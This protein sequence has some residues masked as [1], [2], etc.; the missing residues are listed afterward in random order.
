MELE[1][2]KLLGMETA[3]L[4]LSLS[5][6]EFLV[7]AFS[8]CLQYSLIYLYNLAFYDLKISAH[9]VRSGDSG[10]ISSW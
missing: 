9:L 10:P 5:L 2:G 8:A 1:T 3:T 7:F 6:S 4:S